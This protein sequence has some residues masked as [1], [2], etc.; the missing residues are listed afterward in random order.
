MRTMKIDFV[1]PW[2]DGSDQEWIEQRNR[3]FGDYTESRYR[4]WGVLKYWFRAVE[5]YAPWV[6]RV[7]LVTCG[8]VP[9]WLNT[10]NQKLNLVFHKDYIPDRYLPTFSSHVIELNLHRIKDLSE[11]FVY[12]N[13]DTFLSSPCKEEDF[14]KDG[15]PCDAALMDVI[16][17]AVVGHQFVHILLNNLSLA[18][19]HFN[20]REVMKKKISRWFNLKY[21]KENIKNLYFSLSGGFTGFRNFH[22][23]QSFRK[24]DFR[25]LWALEPQVLEQTSL[26][27]FRGYT[28][29]NQ[30]A[31]RILNL[32]KGEFHPRNPH[33]MGRYFELSR[34]D[35]QIR[36]YML[37]QR[38][39]MVCINDIDA[40]MDF[41]REYR[42]LHEL[43]EQVFPDKSSFEL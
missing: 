19:A 31:V 7:H 4:E 27:K 20:K 39:R 8:Q 22:L 11:S 14:F 34:H 38:G 16:T 41:E 21:G 12:F 15:L 26:N 33:E 28:D 18:N 10:D 17:P 25:E 40:N 5:K 29:V 3:Y 24:S 35:D 30:Y 13:D 32:C 36:D 1:I 37:N 42:F 43:F 9:R 2:V 6:N 23:P